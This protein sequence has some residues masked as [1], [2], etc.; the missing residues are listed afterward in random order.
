MNVNRFPSR[1]AS[2]RLAALAFSAAL[3]AAACGYLR[4]DGFDGSLCWLDG[5]C[6]RYFL[7]AQSLAQRDRAVRLGVP[8]PFMWDVAAERD[9]AAAGVPRWARRRID[10]HVRRHLDDDLPGWQGWTA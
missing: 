6:A 8:H 10:R 1:P 9:A 3:A 5:A 2:L 7:A 4:G